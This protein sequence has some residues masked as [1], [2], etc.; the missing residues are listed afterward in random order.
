[1]MNN[2]IVNNR[3]NYEKLFLYINFV[4]RHLRFVQNEQLAGYYY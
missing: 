2:N 4:I 3:T 1:M